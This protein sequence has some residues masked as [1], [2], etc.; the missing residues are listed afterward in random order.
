M[1]ITKADLKTMQHEIIEAL[2][3]RMDDK[4]RINNDLLRQEIRASESRLEKKIE[5]SELKVLNGVSEMLDGN[6]VP[7]I[8]DLDRRVTKLETETAAV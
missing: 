7:Q 8:E 4:F 5:A 1:E 6:I 2:D 3:Q